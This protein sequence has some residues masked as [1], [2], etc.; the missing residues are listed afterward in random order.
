MLNGLEKRINEDQDIDSERESL[1]F[2][3]IF[4]AIEVDNSNLSNTKFND[5]DAHYLIAYTDN[6]LSVLIIITCNYLTSFQRL[7]NLIVGKGLITDQTLQSYLCLF[8]CSRE[9]LPP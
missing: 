6:V 7:C 4:T 9:G 1:S 3:L 2:Q 8:H 5:R